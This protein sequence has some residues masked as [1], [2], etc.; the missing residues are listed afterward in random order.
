[1]EGTSGLTLLQSTLVGSSNKKFNEVN[2]QRSFSCEGME[3]DNWV[4]KLSLQI[5]I[6]TAPQ[7]ISC[8]LPTPSFNQLAN[9]GDLTAGQAQATVSSNDC[10]L[11]KNS[12]V[13]A[14]FI[15][16]YAKI[17]ECCWQQDLGLPPAPA[18]FPSPVSRRDLQFNWQAQPVKLSEC[19]PR[20]QALLPRALLAPLIQV[21]TWSFRL[22]A[23][24]K[25]L[26]LSFHKLHWCLCS[27][28]RPLSY[29]SLSPSVLFLFFFL[30]P[31]P[32]RKRATV[33]QVRVVGECSLLFFCHGRARTLCQ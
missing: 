22:T 7:G 17:P 20:F 18:E 28:Q 33:T 32:L 30:C 8:L 29:C 6:A 12:M 15:R 1:M 23:G 9:R 24:V 4:S 19:S 26:C 13:D 25:I 16:V 11:G 2:K 21:S 3:S 14:I 31:L 10:C 27:S 5:R